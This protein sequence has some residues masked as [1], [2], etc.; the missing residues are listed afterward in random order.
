MSTDIFTYDEKMKPSVLLTWNCEEEV[1]LKHALIVI[2]DE[3]F[4]PGPS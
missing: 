2:E 3:D 1:A 4:P